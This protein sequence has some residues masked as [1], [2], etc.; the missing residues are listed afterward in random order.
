MGL[1]LQLTSKHLSSSEAM[2]NK[3]G[4]ASPPRLW[5][6]A[7]DTT[8]AADVLSALPEQ[9]Y[10]LTMCHPEQLSNGSFTSLESS[11]E[12]KGKYFPLCRF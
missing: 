7:V 3:S 11:L 9:G 5:P 1:M 8:E 6:V 2:W 12:M 4:A 10:W